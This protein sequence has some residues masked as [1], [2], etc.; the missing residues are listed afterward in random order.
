MY[1][2]LG[3]I[4]QGGRKWGWQSG[5]RR[6]RRCLEFF[7]APWTEKWGLTHICRQGCCGKAPEQGAWYA[8]KATSVKR[9]QELASLFFLPPISEPAANKYTKIDPCVKSV[10]L[11]SWSFGLLR[12]AIGIKPGKKDTGP[13]AAENILEHVDADSAIG[14]P[15]DEKETRAGGQHQSE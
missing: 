13:A 7:G 3:Q 14:V 15:H 6:R 5:G 4:G 10:A 1:M 2:I 9:A 8:N 11:I 12:K